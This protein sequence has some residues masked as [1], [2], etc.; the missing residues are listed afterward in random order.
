LR[1]RSRR[2]AS[3]RFAPPLAILALAIVANSARAQTSSDNIAQA[4]TA[5]A[6]WLN[7]IDQGD[8]RESWVNAASLF[9]DRVTMDQWEQQVGG[10]RGSLGQM[11]S[12][13][14]YNARYM[15][16]LPGAPDGKYVVL[17][18]NTSFAHKKAAIETVTPMMDTDGK[19]RV[20]GYYVR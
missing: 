13:K 12:R 7:L 1:I 20:S 5:A 10:V 17:Q 19:W 4:R 16:S 15:T 14:F 2:H 6:Q 9:K 11:T 18:Y 8:Y 3:F